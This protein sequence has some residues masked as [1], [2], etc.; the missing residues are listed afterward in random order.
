[1]KKI[2]RLILTLI[3][4]LVIFSEVVPPIGADSEQQTLRVAFPIQKGLTEIDESGKYSGY[5]YDY[6]REIS[7]YAGWNYEFV[8]GTG[9]I[10]E[11]LSS[12]I[13]QLRSGKI[14]L[15]GGTL[16]TDAM[17][18]EFDYAAYSYGTRYT[19]LNVLE[20][21]T[22]INESNYQTMKH[23]RIA[24]IETAKMRN[25]EL[26]KFC[27]MSGI[28]PEL[29]V[30]SDGNEQERA[31]RE[32]R[33]DA[34]LNVDVNLLPGTRVIAKFEPTPYYFITRKGNTDL[35]NRLNSAIHAIDE[36]DPYFSAMLYDKYFSNKDRML[37]F[38][39]NEQEY[40]KNHPHLTVGIAGEEPPYIYWDKQEEQWNGI[41]VD[42]LNHICEK[43]GFDFEIKNAGSQQA[44]DEM[45]A[46]G[47]IDLLP[48]MPY[49]YVKYDTEH[50]ALTRAYVSSQFVMVI[51]RDVSADNLYG[52]RLA[53][54]DKLSYQGGFMGKAA[55]YPTMEDCIKAV[56][57]G[58]ADY[59]YADGY[60]V[61][62]YINTL[63]YKNLSLIPQA[64]ELSRMCLGV[65]R[66]VKIDLLT[67]LNKTIAD[68]SDNEQQ[69]MLYHNTV[70][71]H[72][73]TFMD[74]LYSNFVEVI[75][76]IS[77]F[78]L[79]VILLLL[80]II[81]IRTKSMQ[82]ISIDN[83]KYRQLYEF[84]DEHFFEYDYSNKK[85]MIAQHEG[86]KNGI[87]E[88][89]LNQPEILNSAFWEKISS[90]RDGTEELWCDNIDGT[91]QWYRISSKTIYNKAGNAVY[92]IGKVINIQKEKEE[93]ER[94]IRKAQNDS[95]TGIYNIST[96]KHIVSKLLQNTDVRGAFAVFDLDNFKQ[97]NDTY[98]HY[99]GDKVLVETVKCMKEVF[100][101]T[102][103]G[104]LGGDEFIIFMKDIESKDKV[105]EI[106]K[107]FQTKLERQIRQECGMPV[108]ISMGIVMVS[109]SDE[110]IQVYKR[111]D[112]AL[113]Y[114]KQHGRNGIKIV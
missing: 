43:T 42:L 17:A 53:V 37:I 34:M 62:Y 105:M 55:Q 79:C 70:N 6:L 11:D 4:V 24:V 15:I 23:M 69:A 38:N 108:Y 72:Q 77:I 67:I 103:L 101:D 47:E 33:A 50:I 83:Q 3:A 35:I 97:I 8:T 100:E 89:D 91:S 104:R 94:L 52:K 93:K 14:D 111:A 51:N 66:P 109:Q 54:V 76:C 48:A 21:N 61:Q 36:A 58:R 2:K 85:L 87:R 110:Y 95:L 81:Q 88:Y 9:K 28:E 80:Y 90:Q 60:K 74:M 84:T 32:G 112:S 78:A 82:K 46:R 96:A 73:L 57:D 1:M 10:D 92:C 107:A 99:T 106:C 19:V 71:Q 86:D 5:T 30:C 26:D 68:I 65:V 25:E 22:E 29:I 40:I 98:G 114:V 12:M 44:L 41:S 18:K 64:K 31:L 113:Y 59:T 20:E 45:V 63:K 75:I 13:E 102:V 56:N 16:Y 7:Q 27:Q 49:E 39:T